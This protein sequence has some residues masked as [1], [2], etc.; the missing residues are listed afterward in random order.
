ML[1]EMEDVR[2]TKRLLNGTGKIVRMEEEHYE[3]SVF[4]FWCLYYIL[5]AQL[6]V[7]EIFN[8][9]QH[10]E[11]TITTQFYTVMPTCIGYYIILS[12]TLVI[13]INTNG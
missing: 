5:T 7:M 4:V 8:L 9:Q 6:R 10:I 11:L 3:D 2:K 13:S 1:G 12:V